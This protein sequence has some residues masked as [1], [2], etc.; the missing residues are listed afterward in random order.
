MA[1]WLRYSHN[2]TE[3]F[4]TLEGS[5]ILVHSGDMFAGAEATGQT[6]AL[7]DVEVLT[8]CQPS[9][10]I[11]LWNNFHELSAKIGS[12]RPVDPLYFLKAPSAF[13]ADGQTVH[14]PRGF[15]GNVVFEGELGIVIGKRCSN[16]SE[17]E[18]ADHIFG[19]TCVNDVTAADILN[20][21]ASFAQ[22]TRAKSF[23]SFGVFGPAI[24]TGLDPMGLR[25]KTVIGESSITASTSGR[26]ASTSVRWSW[27]ALSRSGRSMT[28][29]APT[30]SAFSLR[31][32]LTAASAVPPG[33]IS[34]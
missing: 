6:V 23:D 1:Q 11:C 32:S 25:I 19:Y 24:A 15:A 14:R 20:K 29:V 17:A 26:V 18:A 16:I 8:P 2:G 34:T 28:K 3:G 10:M 5:Q 4:G 31:S 7:A 33:A 12:T 13:L 30:T 21:D 22:W 9:K 27:L